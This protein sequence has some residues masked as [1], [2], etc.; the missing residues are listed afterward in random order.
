MNSATGR[1]PTKQINI[2]KVIIGGGFPIAIQSMTNTKT[3]DVEATVTQIKALQKAGCEIVRVSV[4]DRPS[5]A[6]FKDIKAQIDIPIVADIHFQA[7]L[8]VAAIKA[9]ADKIRINPGNIGGPEDIAKV[10]Y[11]AA[12]ADIPI[13]I[14]VNSGSL[15]KQVRARPASTAE[16]LA[17]S[18]L[19]NIGLFEESGFDNIVLSVKSSD[20][21][22][23]VK[24]YRLLSAKT[25]Y[26]LHL[27]IT[28]SGTLETGAIKSAIG[29]GLLL[30]EGIGDTIRV[31]LTAEPVHEIDIAKQ[32]LQA[33]GIRRFN[34]EV[35][36]CPTCA[37][38]EVDLIPIAEQL[39]R[40]LKTHSKL[41]K[42]A[43]MGCVVNGPGE[44]ADADIG[45]A[46]GR[47]KGV[48]FSRGLAVKTIKETEFFAELIKMVDEFEVK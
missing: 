1:K 29:I 5:A 30:A 24:A 10:V 23:T 16:K 22:E 18:A 48:I 26:P 6:A 47:G 21:M 36:S 3:A 17:D 41:V 13:R 32:I 34:P 37:R 20:V 8:A 45:L 25:D 4:P 42:V 43:V 40:H 19:E 28:E 9:G 11:A 46:A 31:S 27:G 39:E 38:C 15:S 14:G 7:D 33:L 2:G 12:A 44:A 35:I